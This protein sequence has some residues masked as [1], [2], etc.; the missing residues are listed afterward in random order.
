MRDM[1]GVET[2]IWYWIVYP[3]IYRVLYIPGGC[4]GFLPSTVFP[5]QTSCTC[6]RNSLI[7]PKWVIEVMTAEFPPKQL[8]DFKKKTPSCVFGDYFLPIAFWDKCCG[9]SSCPVWNHW[10]FLH[11]SAGR[12]GKLFQEKTSRVLTLNNGKW[13]EIH[14]TTTAILSKR[15]WS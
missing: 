3:I 9:F 15:I 13:W 7:P 10:I 2:R 5:T 6:I 4:L 12:G 11:P 14:G 8:L 1:R